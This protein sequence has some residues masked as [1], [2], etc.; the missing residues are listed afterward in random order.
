[1]M[2]SSIVQLSTK[3]RRVWATRHTLAGWVMFVVPS[4]ASPITVGHAGGPRLAP[5]EIVRFRLAALRLLTNTMAEPVLT[6][7]TATM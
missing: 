5:M 2:L 7:D 3:A 6:Y 1:M 4:L